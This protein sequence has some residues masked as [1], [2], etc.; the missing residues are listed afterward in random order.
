MRKIFGIFVLAIVF[1]P[2]AV[3]AQ[4]TPPGGNPL[5]QGVSVDAGRIG[6]ADSRADNP[7]Q[8][9]GDLVVNLLNWFAWF[10]AV[11]AVVMGLYSGILFITGGGDAAKLAT[12][13]K[14]LLWA[15]VG[16]AVAVL[17]FSIVAISTAFIGLT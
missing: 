17:S 1:M 9:V 12:A 15:V 16:I 7:S 13:R 3:F 2:M 11:I 14:I 6:S 8:F 10:I 5:L 4:N